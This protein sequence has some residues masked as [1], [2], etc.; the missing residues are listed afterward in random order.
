MN[1]SIYQQALDLQATGLHEWSTNTLAFGL[2]KYIQIVIPQIAY[3]LIYPLVNAKTINSL[4]QSLGPALSPDCRQQRA[5]HLAD[6]YH[7]LQGFFTWKLACDLGFFLVVTQYGPWTRALTLPGLITYTIGQLILY[8]LVGQR[9]ILSRLYPKQAPKRPKNLRIGRFQLALSRLFHEELGVTVNQVPLRVALAKMLVDY[10][11]MYLT[12]S[13][14]TI[15]FFLIGQGELDFSPLAIFPHVS[16]VSFYLC[17]YLGY[18]FSFTLLNA[19]LRQCYL[20]MPRRWDGLSGFLLS[21][22]LTKALGALGSMVLLPLGLS[23]LLPIWFAVGQISVQFTR[24]LQVW[25][26]A[27]SVPV[28]QWPPSTTAV[29]PCSVDCLQQQ[30]AHQLRQAPALAPLQP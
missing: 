3:Y 24:P 19:L 6:Q 30:V 5:Q 16:M 2:A 27:T 12:W 29:S 23:M 1:Y 4:L 14:Y 22:E 15:G 25:Q 7:R 20:L 10:V 21:S 13:L 11:V 28:P 26:G 9:L 18:A 17:V 8:F